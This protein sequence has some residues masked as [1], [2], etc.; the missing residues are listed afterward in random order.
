[1]EVALGAERGT[2][3]GGL[4]GGVGVGAAD[5]AEIH[6]GHWQHLEFHPMGPARFPARF[7]A[8]GGGAVRARREQVL[9]AAPWRGRRGDAGSRRQPDELSAPPPANPS[10]W[11]PSP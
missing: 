1:D 6:G 4:P 11:L 2:Q 9:A 8:S 3:G 5:A 10:E 7:T